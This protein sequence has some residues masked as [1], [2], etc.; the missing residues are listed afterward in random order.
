MVCFGTSSD[1]LVG[2]AGFRHP[3]SGKF[4]HVQTFMAQVLTGLVLNINPRLVVSTGLVS[5]RRWSLRMTKNRGVGRVPTG[6]AAVLPLT[7][8]CRLTLLFSNGPCSGK[9]KG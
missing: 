9:Y 4:P 3:P 1:L 2:G 6:P 5:Q 8:D 7:S